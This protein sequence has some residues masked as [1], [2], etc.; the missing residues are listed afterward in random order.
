MVFAVAVMAFG[1]D[2]PVSQSTVDVVQAEQSTTPADT[3]PSD[4]K[5]LAAEAV[6]QQALTQAASSDKHVLVH[7]G[8]PW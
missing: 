4:S 8:A 2:K 3:P 7:L 1:C 6:L 5:D